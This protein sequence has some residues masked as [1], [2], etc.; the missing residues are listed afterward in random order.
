MFTSVGFRSTSTSAS[1]YQRINVETAVSEASPHQLVSLLLD[2]FLQ[3]VGA[4]RTAMLRGDVA[5]K[6][7]QIGRAVRMIDEALKPALNLEKGGELA[8]NLNG[9]YGYCVLRLT[10]ANLKNDDAALADVLRVMEPI[11]QGW[12]Q[13]GIEQSDANRAM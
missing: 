12:K 10:D 6:G 7:R 9:L 2:G 4:A 5:T 3:A 11:A 8:A 1:A 13:M